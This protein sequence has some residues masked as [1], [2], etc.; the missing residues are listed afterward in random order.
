MKSRNEVEFADQLS[1]RR[2]IGTAAAAI[3]FLGIQL[4]AHPVFR[5]DDYI[6]GGIRPYMWAVNAF[7]LLLLVLPIGGWIWGRRVRELVN[8]EISRGHGRAATAAGFWVAVLIAIAIH[9]LPLGRELTA[10]ETTY[11]IVSPVAVLVPLYFAW[12]EARALRDG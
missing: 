8:D 7:V 4:V 2:Y 10:R 9:V 5:S 12:L 1:R 3:A 6:P 11:L